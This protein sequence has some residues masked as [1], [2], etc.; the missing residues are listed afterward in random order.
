MNRNESHIKYG[1]E[2]ELINGAE[3][4]DKT[5]ND[6]SIIFTDIDNDASEVEADA[7]SIAQFILN[8]I[9]NDYVTDKITKLLRHPK[10]SDFTLLPLSTP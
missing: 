4:P 10:F 6:V 3:Y 9:Q 2:E 5:S 1:T 7:K 8:S